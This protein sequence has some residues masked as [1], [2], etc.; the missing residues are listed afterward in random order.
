MDMIDKKIEIMELYDLYQDLL[1]GKQKEYIEA[2]YY[3]D[4]SIGEIAEELVISRNAVHDQLKRSVKKLYDFESSLHL[5]EKRVFRSEIIS[6]MKN[7]K[8][9]DALKALILE[10]EK[11]E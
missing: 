8:D 4:E 10:L 3:D 6:K 7:E 9:V 5:R 2:Y 1:T 11:G